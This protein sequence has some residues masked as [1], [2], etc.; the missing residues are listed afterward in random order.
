VVLKRRLE[1]LVAEFNEFAELDSAVPA[2]RRV[3][4]A[5][6][7]ACRPWESSVVNALKKRRS[8]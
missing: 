1:R 5:L 8:P 7:A 6:L 3:G 2:S 4:V